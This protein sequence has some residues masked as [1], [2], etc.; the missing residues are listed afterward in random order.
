MESQ[1]SPGA[2]ILV[3]SDTTAWEPMTV[4]QSTGFGDALTVKAHP[5]SGPESAARTLDKEECAQIQECDNLALQGA[6][7]LVKFSKLNE[8]SLLQNLR[9]RYMKDDI[10]SRAG[11]IL[12][13]V[14]PFKQLPIYTSARMAQCKVRRL[15]ASPSRVLMHSASM[16]CFPCAP[17]C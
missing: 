10:Y 4:V 2:I 7:D 17:G 12:I 6:P 8:A 3:P 15:S 13:S 9:V 5:L 1:Y 11:S 16:S 14:N